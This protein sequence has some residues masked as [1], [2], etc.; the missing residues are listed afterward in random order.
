MRPL[1]L[2]LSAFGPYAGETEIDFQ[3][4]G[5]NGLYLIAGD[6]GAGKTTIFD[7]IC[8]ALYGEAS[9]SSREVSML[10]SKYAAVTTPTYVELL[11]RY[12]G[13]D[14]VIRRNP[15]YERPKGRGEGLTRQRAEGLL[16]YPDGR[17]LTKLK[18]LTPAVENII[19]L[20]RAQFS[21]I[22]MIAQGDFLK[23]LLADTK[24]RQ[25]IFRNIFNTGLYVELQNKLSETSG[26]IKKQWE[27]VRLGMNQYM[28]NI[29]WDEDSEFSQDAQKAKRGELPGTEL[30]E[31]LKKLIY[32]DEA[33]RDMLNNEI[34]DVEKELERV[35]SLI[36]YAEENERKLIALSEAE[37][38]KQSLQEELKELEIERLKHCERIPEQELIF[39]KIS[40]LEF[41]MESY[42]ELDKLR[43]E[44][45][46][47]SADLGKAKSRL[48]S[49]SE[50]SE[51][52]KRL[53]ILYKEEISG[54]NDL[55]AEKERINSKLNDLRRQF[56]ELNAIISKLSNLDVQRD[57][58]EELQNAYIKAELE[59]TKL[60]N[61]Y[62]IKNRT[63]LKAQAGLMAKELEAG[64]PCPVCGSLEHPQLA[65]LEHDVPAEKE[66]QQA[67][68][69]ASKARELMEK[70]S[71]SAGEQRTKL[72]LYEKELS[73][74]LSNTLNAS[75]LD[76]A[77]ELTEK[78]K[79]EIETEGKTLRKHL[80]DILAREQRRAELES[81]LTETEEKLS[82]QEATKSEA[83]RTVATAET[84][85]SKT[86][87][88]VEE[89][90]ERLPYKEKDQAEKEKKL[91]SLR[92]EGMKR[93]QAEAE[94]AYAICEKESLSI[95]GIVDELRRGL[96]NS[97]KVDKLKLNENKDRLTAD[98][99]KL[100]ARIMQLNIR[101][102]QN[103][104][105]FE[106]LISKSESMEKLESKLKWVQS[107]AQTA[108]GSI[109]G[110]EKIALETYIQTTY[111]DRIIVRAN[112]RLMKMSSG[113]YELK[114]QRGASRLVGQTGLELNVVDHYNG[115]ERSVKTLSGGESFKA[116]L[117]LALGLSDEIQMST[118]IK[119]DTMFVDEGFGS[120]DP[121]SLSQA[122]RS[123]A[124]LTEGNR[125]VGIISHVAELKDRIDRQIVVT[126]DKSGG[127]SVKLIV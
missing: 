46:D 34:A 30:T 125:L 48:K 126:K 14:Y 70:A 124:D 112:V 98:K 118:G 33:K 62:E 88:Q 86:S 2:T 25:E 16:I 54:L 75:Q 82:E 57:K 100:N 43:H 110:K 6:T 29:V 7:A 73:D 42:D 18:E 106:G 116:S 115:S 11:F 80:N 32:E 12:A 55:S 3:S 120:L 99:T 69:D 44:L 31:L 53:L 20:D 39:Q 5:E 64:N 38:K 119:L 93:Q 28:E 85:I 24:Q 96:E 84:L 40:E 56:E 108:N 21:Q 97:N 58:L 123:L 67:E 127:S 121:E 105:A 81:L 10:R 74:S 47:Y 109:A 9:G 92:L 103:Q 102:A 36:S 94:N 89:L 61:A 63:F 77:K 1:K 60:Q 91:L 35:I 117:A 27:E 22:A 114:R 72:K 101:I 90:L 52:L 8:Y 59:Y 37:I 95:S 104:T 79:L 87:A 49:A 13:K 66:V 111:F 17:Q 41:T 51:E 26:T 23:L 68:K 19:G 76:S 50:N 107:L 4:L 78:K 83:I 122:Y 15:E 113:Q 71:L 65:K 45:G